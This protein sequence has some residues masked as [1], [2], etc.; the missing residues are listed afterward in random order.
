MM[1]V[2]ASSTDYNEPHFF[3]SSDHAGAAN[4]GKCH[5]TSETVILSS[6]GAPNSL[7]HPSRA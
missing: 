5:A 4:D 6:S 1:Y 2:D 7:N 3:Q